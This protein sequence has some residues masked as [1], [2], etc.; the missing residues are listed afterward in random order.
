MSTDFMLGETLDYPQDESGK[1]I[2][3]DRTEEQWANAEAKAAAN[4]MRLH[5]TG[6]YLVVVWAAWQDGCSMTIPDWAIA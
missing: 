2:D 5:D 3:E 1:W 6:G 4:G